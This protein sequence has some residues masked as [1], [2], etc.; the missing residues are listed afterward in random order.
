MALTAA[1]EADLFGRLID[2]DESAR[3]AA[4]RA[5]S[6]SAEDEAQMAHLLALDGDA[7]AFLEREVNAALHLWGQSSDFAA[8]ARVGRFV[9]LRELGRGGMAEVWLVEYEEAGV[10][11]RAALKVLRHLSSRAEQRETWERERRLAARLS[12]PYIA[13]MIESGELASGLPYLL[14][15]YVEGQRMEEALAGKGLR[16][17]VEILRKVCEA[18]GAA[19]RQFVVHRDLKPTNILITPD[20]LPKLV[21]FG[22]GH[23]LDLQQATVPAATAAFA[24]PEQIAGEEPTMAS[25]VYSLG[26]I[27]QRLASDRGR[28]LD[29]ISAKATAPAP[30]DRYATVPEMEEELRRW[31]AGRPVLAFGR[32]FAY[33]LRCLLRRHRAASAGVALA[34]AL[35]IVALVVAWQQF[36]QAQSRTREL[37]S[38][39]SVAIFD[40]DEEVRKLPGSLPARRMILETATTYLANLESAARLDPGARAELANAYQ[41]TSQLLFAQTGQSAQ[42]Q[43]DSFA[44]LEKSYRLRE[45]LGQFASRDSKLR[46]AYAETARDYGQQLRLRRRVE[47]SDRVME[48]VEQHVANWLREEPRSWQALE[49]DLLLGNMRTRRLRLQ[50]LLPAVENQRRVVARLAEFRAATPPPR[51][52][53]RMA[54]LQNQLMSAVLTDDSLRHLAPELFTAAT[55]AVRA[56]EEWQRIEPTVASTRL[57]LTIYHEYVEHTSE[58]G[59][60]PPNEVARLLRRSDEILSSP[61]LPDRAATYWEKNRLELLKVR[62]W[63][64]A[65]QGDLAAMARYFAECRERLDRVKPQ[66]QMWVAILRAQLGMKEHEVQAAASGNAKPR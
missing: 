19:H 36:R 62:G 57:L 64:A 16:E 12:H 66:E 53:W 24:S 29:A 22:I 37:Q 3:A 17:R 52:Y 23:A 60:A 33:R 56:V 35:M 10:N 13:G 61:D 4:L 51:N 5:A 63:A 21:D 34:V 59:V 32:G 49:E 30:Q 55:D 40:L 65:A 18:V 38:L 27:L 9:L 26:R 43:A 2:L 42:R 44:L 48:R 50:G 15:E 58:M 31:L 20:G 41:K 1:E 47:E 6:L 54:A 28:E 39:A 45:E 8:G 25:D 14:M 46:Q 7:A 11:R